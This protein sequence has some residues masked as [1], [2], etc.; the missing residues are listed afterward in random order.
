LAFL[1]V[2]IGGFLG[3]GCIILFFVV[4]IE[5]FLKLLL[6]VILVIVVLGTALTAGDALRFVGWGLG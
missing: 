6:V 5:Q 3:I 1:S 4:L 2:G